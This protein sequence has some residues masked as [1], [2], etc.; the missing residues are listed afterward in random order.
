MGNELKT[1]IFVRRLRSKLHL[2]RKVSHLVTPFAI[3]LRLFGI[4]FSTQGTDHRIGHLVGEPYYMYLR[5]K[6]SIFFGKLFILLIPQGICANKYVISNLPKNFIVITNPVLCKILYLFRVNPISAVKTRNVFVWDGKA[7][8]SLRYSE[9]TLRESRFISVPE[10][11]SQQIAA[12]FSEMGI[13][14]K[15]WFVCLHIREAGYAKL[16][17]DDITEFRNSDISTY[18]PAIRLIISLGGIVVRMGDETMTPMPEISG[19]VDYATSNFKSDEND[20]Y[21]MSHCKYFIGSNSGANWIAIAQQRR[22][23]AVNVAPMA[24]SKIWTSQDLAVPKIHHRVSDNSEVPFKEIFSSDLA[25]YQM[26]YKYESAG[27]VTVDNSED[28][29]L[30]AVMEFHDMVVNDKVFSE[31]EKAL[32]EAFNSLFTEKNF[33]Y[34]SQT[35]VSP[36]FLAKYAHLLN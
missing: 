15:D 36:Y 22:I 33:G 4:R 10:R 5:S 2:K 35:K 25:D 21:L 27:I 12:L 28:E 19:L 20:F 14:E 18:L 1:K 8:E 16:L 17:D 6:R 29:I 26:S 24:V 32:Q 31:K 23:L 30:N 9:D 7:V 13:S 11:K 34:Y 3:L